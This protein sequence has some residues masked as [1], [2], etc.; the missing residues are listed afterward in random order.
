[1]NTSENKRFL[2]DRTNHLYKKWMSVETVMQLFEDSVREMDASEESVEEKNRA[3]LEEY[4]EKV[5]A[6]TP[7]TQAEMSALY[8]EQAAARQS[9]F[10]AAPKK[11]VSFEAAVIV[12]QELSD[13]RK[14]LLEAL[15]RVDALRAIV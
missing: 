8:E 10:Q 14:M 15:E 11:G 13:L 4:P 9:S 6:L 7:K 2:W 1:M 3:F 5:A 12:Q